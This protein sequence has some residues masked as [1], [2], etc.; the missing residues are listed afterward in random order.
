MS[1]RVTP[2]LGMVFGKYLSPAHQARF[3][4]D[5]RKPHADLVVDTNDRNP[6]GR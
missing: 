5:K 4:S 6:Q 2:P 1:M 3:N